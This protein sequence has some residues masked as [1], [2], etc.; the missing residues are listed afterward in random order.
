VEIFN[1]FKELSIPSQ[2]K[3]SLRV[4]AGVIKS[5]NVGELFKDTHLFIDCFD[6]LTKNIMITLLP[7][8]SC[9]VDCKAFFLVTILKKKKINIK[10]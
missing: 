4:P 7:L 5:M 6:N 3:K 1:E 8:F 10:I 2:R 9:S